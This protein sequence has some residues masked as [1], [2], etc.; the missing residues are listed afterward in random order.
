MEHLEHPNAKTWEEKKLW[1]EGVLERHQH[2]MAS[3]LVSDR[4][5]IAGRNT[6]LLLCR[7]RCKKTPD[8]IS[9]L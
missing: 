6:M 5:C 3:Y 7:S 9:Q 1:F 2:P 8:L 4:Y